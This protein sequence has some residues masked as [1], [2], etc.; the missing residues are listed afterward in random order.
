MVS[1][2]AGGASTSCAIGALGVSDDFSA[3][4]GDCEMLG[5][6]VIAM[7]VISTSSTALSAASTYSADSSSSY[8]VSSFLFS[9]GVG[10]G[11]FRTTG[12]SSTAGGAPVGRDL[13]RLWRNDFG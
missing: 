1:L 9:D 10:D 5:S 8:M 12:S 4:S 2:T 7:P 13:E 6:V 11:I 3:A